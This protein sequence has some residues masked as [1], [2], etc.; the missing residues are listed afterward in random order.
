MSNSSKDTNKQVSKKKKTNIL[1]SKLQQQH[2]FTYSMY[3]AKTMPLED[4]CAECIYR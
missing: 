2:D 1:I 4:F 3:M